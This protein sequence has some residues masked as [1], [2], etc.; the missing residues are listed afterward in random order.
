MIIFKVV[1]AETKA[2]TY[3]LRNLAYQRL[4]A[5][6]AVLFA[7][8]QFAFATTVQKD[9]VPSLRSRVQVQWSMPK[10]VRFVDRQHARFI[11]AGKTTPG[12]KIQIE[13]GAALVDSQMRSYDLTF[14]KMAPNAKQIIVGP[15]GQFVFYLTLPFTYVQIP[16]Q[17][18]L[19]KYSRYYILSTAINKSSCLQIAARRR[20][21]KKSSLWKFGLEAR[22]VSFSQTNK[23]NLYENMLAATT[24]YKLML[25]KSWSAR[26]DAFIDLA[27]ATPFSTNQ[28]E[29][30]ARF[31]GLNS[32]LIYLIP[33]RSK[34]WS[35]GVVGGFYY[36]TML[37]SGQ[38]FGYDNLWG[39]EIY[40]ILSYTLNAKNSF[41]FYY[42]YA[43]VYAQ[44]SV[45]FSD[46]E[47]DMGVEWARLRRK[48]RTISIKLDL[49]QDQFIEQGANTQ[50]TAI[51]LGVSYGVP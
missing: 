4:W 21:F 51:N 22:S 29:M 8:P 18:T 11:I 43:P 14:N 3:V 33:M 45:S 13:S 49:L 1:F 38:S 30:S 5:V 20:Q 50:S 34:K 24:S 37:P 35:L 46:H 47:S 15:G 26:A 25:S 9:V 6:F 48:K 2:M 39:P 27:G 16:F 19:K 31:W 36:T 7:V 10:F 32:D 42:K 12:V 17:A 41:H 23:N 40:P 44:D 28:N